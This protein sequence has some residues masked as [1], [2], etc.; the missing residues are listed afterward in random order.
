[1]NQCY[2]WSHRTLTMKCLISL[3]L[4][5]S[6]L[7]LSSSANWCYQTQVSCGGHCKGPEL[8]KDVN[9]DCGNNRQSPINI[10][11]KKTKLDERLT[12][13][14]F[15]GYETKFDSIIKNTGHS[16]QVDIPNTLTVSG[17]NLGDT[18]KAVQFHLHWGTKGGPGSEHTID[19]EQYPMELHIVHIK[20]RYNKIEDA[21]KDP[22]DIAVLGFFYEVSNSANKGY[23][24]LIDALKKIQNTNGNMTLRKISLS[25]FILSE[26]KMTNY[27]RYDGSLTTP[28]CNEVVVW[29]VFENPIPISKEQLEKFSS[30]K[31]HD[32]K[33]MELTF[34]PVQSRNGRVVY[35]SSGQV[36]VAS[37]LLLFT[38]VT[39]AFS[40][41]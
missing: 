1:M 21:L 37:A 17:G 40:L 33:T 23:D 3:Y 28:G 11:T 2:C 26:E 7:H 22:S 8:W 32:G 16:V 12:P 14:K 25:Q 30:L 4:L 38:S 35:R 19:G 24:Q 27:Y 13:L 5:T 29:T 10:V 18:Y 41:I 15:N 20:Q 34:R 31:F 9:R 36:V 39:T 6:I